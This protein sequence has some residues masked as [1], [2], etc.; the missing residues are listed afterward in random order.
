MEGEIKIK[1]KKTIPPKDSRKARLKKS[2]II[3]RKS[4]SV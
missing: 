4:E 1:N 3:R 2:H